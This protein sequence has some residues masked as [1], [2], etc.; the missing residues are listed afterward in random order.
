[1]IEGLES[2]A[3]RTLALTEEWHEVHAKPLNVPTSRPRERW[4]PPEEG[5]LKFNTDGSYSLTG[6]YGGG[7][8][9]VRNHNG[10]FVAGASHFSPNAIDLEGA[11]VM[12]CKRAAELTKEIG[13]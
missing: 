5:L 11:E 9:V 4:C 12:A 1:M 13:C 8:V 10:F 7:G 6:K 2:I 3:R